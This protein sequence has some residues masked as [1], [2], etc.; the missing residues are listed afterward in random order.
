MLPTCRY[1]EFAHP[2][3]PL[4]QLVALQCFQLARDLRS[5]SQVAIC[6]T[7]CRLGAED[8]RR[9]LLSSRELTANSSAGNAKIF[10]DRGLNHTR[11]HGMRSIVL[12]NS[13]F[14]LAL[15]SVDGLSALSQLLVCFL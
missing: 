11:R 2:A 9:R 6:R 3:R 12:S 13:S 5:G 15:F 1:E 14:Q 7:V 4:P 8:G 10:Q